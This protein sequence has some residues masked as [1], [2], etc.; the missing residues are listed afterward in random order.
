MEATKELSHI[1]RSNIF[2]HLLV[3]YCKANETDKA[4]GLWTLL[5]EE[6]EI[7]SDQFLEHL[8]KHLRAKNRPV[9]FVLPKQSQTEPPKKELNTVKV[10][11]EENA[12]KA[13][14]KYAVEPKASPKDEITDKIEKLIQNGQPSQAMDE[15]IKSMNNKIVPK[16]NVIKYL[17]KTLASEGKVEKIEQLGQLLTENMKKKVTYDNKLTSARFERG[18]GTSHIDDLIKTIEQATTE[19]ELQNSLRKFPRSNALA[20]LVNNDELVA[21]CKYFIF[22]SLL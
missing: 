3:S 10:K 4:L 6:G 7:P 17:L 15:L 20:S 16:N 14:E 19:T 11:I 22:I 2:Y 8:A 18:A 12:A 9:P 21:K 5:Q 13:Q 1:D